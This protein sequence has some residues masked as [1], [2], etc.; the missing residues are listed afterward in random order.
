MKDLKSFLKAKKDTAIVFFTYP[1]NILPRGNYINPID[2][3]ILNGQDKYVILRRS[4]KC[5]GDTFNEFENLVDNIILDQRIPGLSMNLLGGNYEIKHLKFNQT[6]GAGKYW[7]SIREIKLNE[8][9]KD[10]KLLEVYCPIYFFVEDLQN[11]EFPYSRP[12]D[13]TAKKLLTELGIPQQVGQT[14]NVIAKVEI[15]HKPSNANYWHVEFTIRES[16]HENAKAIKDANSRWKENL[17]QSIYH[18]ISAKALKKCPVV[19]KVR[20][21]AYTK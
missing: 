10:I 19:P 14:A 8:Y 20:T 5:I 3:N 16:L 6:G 2:I 18:L 1:K 15:V 21:T 7:D 4:D 9:L 12:N 13:A 17:T 11:I